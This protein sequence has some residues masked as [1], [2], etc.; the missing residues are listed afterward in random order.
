MH[1]EPIEPWYHF[2]AYPTSGLLCANRAI[3]REASS[4]FYGQNIFDFTE[5]NPNRVV[6][7]LGQIGS[8]NAGYIRHILIDFP[9]F[10]YPDPGEVTLEKDVVGMLELIQHEC[11]DLSTISTSLR[12]TNSMEV[13]LDDLDNNKIATEA[14]ELVDSRFRNISSIEK[15]IV[16]V[17]EDGPSGH[18]R[19]RMESHG[20]VVNQNERVEE[21]E[22]FSD[23][24]YD[25]DYD[26]G[27]GYSSDDVDDYDIDNDSDFWRRAGD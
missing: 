5:A 21:E 19:R 15:I 7:F 2:Q 17:F 8:T 10:L 4:V 16:E 22:R 18:I 6:S 20:W 1:T 27:H 23:F 11:T 14:L 25:D 9:S 13:R 3:H 26:N 12:S 24:D